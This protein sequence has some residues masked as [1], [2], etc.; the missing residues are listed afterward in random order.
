MAAK[1]DVLNLVRNL[2]ARAEHKNTPEAERELCFA[3]ANKLMTRHAIEE[4]ELRANQTESERRKPTSS[5]WQ[6]M[7]CSDELQPY[8][9]TIIAEVAATNRC[10]AVLHPMRWGFRDGTEHVTAEVTV[11]GF[12]EDVQWC[13]MLY[14]NIYMALLRTMFPRWDSDL[15]FDNNVYNFKRA[16][17]KWRVIAETA[18]ANGHDVPMP[19]NDG[20]LFIK[21]YKRHA[22]LVGDTSRVATQ[23]FEAY[24]RSFMEGFT[25]RVAARLEGMRADSAAESTGK[26]LVLSRSQDDVNAHYYELFPDFHPDAVRTKR[27]RE[28]ERA[29]VLREQEE[30]AR[31][32]LLDGMTE[33]QRAAFLEKEERKRRQQARS[34]AAYWRKRE[35]EWAPDEYGQVQ[36]RAAGNAVNLNRASAVD[37]DERLALD[38]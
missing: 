6:F 2:L 4:A 16:G 27:E 5:K 36:G 24:R 20:H 13:E 23:R 26:E 35:K 12:A 34:D 25:A 1:N 9:R 37:N 11:V 38:G 19:P 31:Q 8:L 10:R 3:Q 22:A 15:S 14:T 30:A 17:Y 33:K 32:S 18:M 21:A 28:L 7:D 29:R